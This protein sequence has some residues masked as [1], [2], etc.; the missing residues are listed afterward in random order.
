MIKYNII[1]GTYDIST[2]NMIYK[3]ENDLHIYIIHTA[4]NI[5]DIKFI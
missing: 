5:C 1:S 2:V 3:I 4:Y